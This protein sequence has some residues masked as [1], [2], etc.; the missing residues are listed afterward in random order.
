MSTVNP[1]WAQ[2]PAKLLLQFTP[3]QQEAGNHIPVESITLFGKPLDV[4]D[5]REVTGDDRPS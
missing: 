2:F 4:S 1:E 3:S 5:T